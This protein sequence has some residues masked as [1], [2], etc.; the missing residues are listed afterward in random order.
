MRKAAKFDMTQAKGD[1]WTIVD[2]IDCHTVPFDHESETPDIGRPPFHTDDFGNRLSEAE[3]ADFQKA[4][5][6]KK[7]SLPLEAHTVLGLDPRRAITKPRFTYRNLGENEPG[8]S[9]VP[10][11]VGDTY[12]DVKHEFR[13]KSGNLISV[14]HVPLPEPIV[15]PVTEPVEIQAE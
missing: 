1:V 6:D 5:Q 10:A 7:H 15:E 12:N 3:Y 9:Y 4:C 13:D 11:S 8:E 2:I 14:V